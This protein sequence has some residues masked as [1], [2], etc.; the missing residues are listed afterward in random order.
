MKLLQCQKLQAIGPQ[1][2]TT[3]TKIYNQIMD[4]QDVNLTLYQKL[5]LLQARFYEKLGSSVD[6]VGIFEVKTSN[7]DQVYTKIKTFFN[8][9]NWKLVHPE[10]ELKTSFIKEIQENGFGIENN[11]A[12]N[13]LYK[14]KR[15][16]LSIKDEQIIDIRMAHFKNFIGV[17]I[18]CSIPRQ[19][20]LNKYKKLNDALINDLKKYLEQ[21][22][23]IEN[24]SI[25]YAI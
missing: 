11:E 7:F 22:H 14:S 25:Q 20:I 12:G 3:A 24:F 2:C 4:T 9:D 1:P 5:K 8:T 15:N 6:K 16:F 23:Q 13:L 18:V 17:T 10:E 19:S 21:Y